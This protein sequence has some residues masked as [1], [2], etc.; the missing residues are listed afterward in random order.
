MKNIFSSEFYHCFISSRIGPLR[1]EVRY[2]IMVKFIIMPQEDQDTIIYSS[3]YT[4]STMILNVR[5][6]Y[7][8]NPFLYS[9][10]VG[11]SRTNSHAIHASLNFTAIHIYA[12]AHIQAKY[13]LL[14]LVSLQVTCRVLAWHKNW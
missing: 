9:L 11:Y 13:F 1:Y 3:L 10:L 2:Y 5:T 14:I 7:F 12:R 8:N 6:L 4:G